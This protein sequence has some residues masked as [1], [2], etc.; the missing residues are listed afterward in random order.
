VDQLRPQDPAAARATL[1]A[2][3][4]KATIRL[5]AKLEVHQV[6]DA[7]AAAEAVDRL[8]FDDSPEGERL[9]R[10]QLAG[11]RAVLRTL[12]VLGKLGRSEP[13]RPAAGEPVAISSIGDVLTATIGCGPEG[14]HASFN[15]DADLLPAVA[16]TP[17]AP[18]P[19]HDAENPPN[20]PTAAGAEPPNAPAGS[21][22]ATGDP[23]ISPNEPTAPAGEHTGSQD[24]PPSPTDEP[25]GPHQEPPGAR[26]IDSPTPASEAVQRPEGPQES[27]PGCNP[28]SPVPHR[29]PAA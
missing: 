2:I 5:E 25:G 10:F 21:S 4:E 17:A 15:C 18:Q 13:P 7:L 1:R 9:R 19:E 24:E 11:Q 27:S 29:S 26:R 20:E 12:D 8:S 3:V 28:G 16:V 14:I 23:T 6:Q 22:A